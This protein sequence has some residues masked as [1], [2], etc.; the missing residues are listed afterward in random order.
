MSFRFALNFG[1]FCREPT[2]WAKAQSRGARARCA[3]QEPREAGSQSRKDDSAVERNFYW[4]RSAINLTWIE[5][6]DSDTTA[7]IP[8]PQRL[9]ENQSAEVAFIGIVDATNLAPLV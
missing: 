8:L 1:R 2:F 5:P 9:I 4:D 3:G 7:V 6:L